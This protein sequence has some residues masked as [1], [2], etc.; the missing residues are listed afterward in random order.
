MRRNGHKTTSGV[1]FDLK[2]DFSSPDYLH[3]GKCLKLDHDFMYLLANFLLRMR[4]NGQNSTSGQIFN[5]IWNPMGCFVFE[6]EY[7]F[8]WGFRQDIY[9]FWAKIG[10]CNAK[11]FQ[12]LDAGKGKGDRFLTKPPKGTSL[13]DFTHF[14]PLCAQIRS[15]VFTTLHVM[16]TRSSD[17]NSVR[18]SVRPSDTRVLWQ[19]G[20]KICPDLYTI[21]K[22]IYPSF[23]RKE[24]LV[25][26]DPFYLKFW[27]NWPPLER[28]RRF[29][30][31]NRL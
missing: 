7:E 14:E 13:A 8:W 20:K 5:T 24:W 9:V 29:S 3:V 18:L 12:N 26:G 21:R 10:F 19:N 22:N 25:G 27:V 31:N 15:R 28:N 17:K 6:Y 16:Q 23:L 1:K 30:T 4:R 2:L 11:I